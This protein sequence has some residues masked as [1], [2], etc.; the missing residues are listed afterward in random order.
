M[1]IEAR[2][3]ETR[4][5]SGRQLP[6][7]NYQELEV[8]DAYL[9][10]IA[11]SYPN[12]VTLVQPATTFEGRPI[13]Y[14]K[15]STTNFQDTSKP[16]IFIDGGIHSRE[17]I[18]P[19][20]VTWAIK[21]LVED[22]TEPDL[23]ERFDWIILP[24]VN[25]DG[26]KFSFTTNR[27]WRKTRST[28]QHSLSYLC[29]GVD[30]NRNYDFAW[31][32][33]GTSNNPC[34]DTFAGSR[35]FSEIETQVVRDIIQ[36]NL[37]RM[38][39]YLTMH[40]YGSMIL[41]PWGHDG[42]LSNNAFALHSVGIAMTDAIHSKAINYFPR[43]VVGNSLLVIGYG[44][45]G[46]AEDYAHSVGVPLSYTY[47][48]PGLSGGFEG[49][50]LDPR[51]IEQVCIE[52]WEGIVVG[53]R[54]AGDLWKSLYLKPTSQEQLKLIGA[55]ADAYEV[56]IISHPILEREGVVLVKPQHLDGFVRALEE[57]DV[58][59]RVHAN[60]VKAARSGR[61]L[62]YDNYQDLEVIDAYL[63]DIAARFPN[64]VTLVHPATTFEGRPIKYLKISTTNF[65]DTSKPVIFID[66]GIHSREWIS[67]PTVTW[68]I[69][70]LVEDNRFWRKTRSTD[71]HSLSYLCPGVDGNRNYDFAWNT[72]GT[73]SNPC[74]D[75]YGGSR[76]FSEIE[77]QVVRNII[78]ENLHR[79]ALY[80]TMH[81][82]GSMILYPWGHDGS[83]S[84]NAFA[85]HSVG[86]AMADV[87]HS[88]AISYFPRYV[89][90]NS[91]LVIGYG[92]SGAAEDYAHSVGVPLSYTYELPGLSWGFEGFHLNPR[93]IE[94][95]CIETWE[96]IVVGARRA[97][98][99]FVPLP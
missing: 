97:G 67:P 72:V 44:T 55:L 58:S 64:L 73:S 31:N 86:I 14:L 13:K 63:D 51:Y 7:D 71:Q 96:G 75:T 36:E 1:L 42:S 26:Y 41:Y 50:H 43:Y 74:T 98:D 22:V 91:L 45:S 61:Q 28:D 17:W 15:I 66:G 89:V 53:A 3:N 99:L 8:I 82:Y 25:P 54:R 27:F 80:L 92:A 29:P 35:A 6:Y 69:K 87:I 83:L 39:L 84:N 60:D 88:K 79:M 47:E 68:A 32:T 62:P 38:A 24:V 59:Y 52:T 40:S 2:K 94:Q 20:T 5:R 10:D 19:P 85:L 33:V 48:L 4:A 77:T 95:V 30:G 16:V 65:Q 11:A 34:A 49:F 21:K 78:Q 18:S 12:L 37:H 9:D 90:G 81:S 93:Y 57:Q 56:D 76:A 46:A 70:K 23:L